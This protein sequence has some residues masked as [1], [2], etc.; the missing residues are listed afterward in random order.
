MLHNR[1]QSYRK[2]PVAPNKNTR[3]NFPKDLMIPGPAEL[4]AFLTI[5]KQSMSLGWSSSRRLMCLRIRQ[6]V[7]EGPKVKMERFTKIPV[8]SDPIWGV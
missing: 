7:E 1:N 2:V 8:K 3:K 6:G 5:L 4:A